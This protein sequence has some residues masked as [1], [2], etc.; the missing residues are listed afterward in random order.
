[1][2]QIYKIEK[3]NDIIEFLEKFDNAEIY[4]HPCFKKILEDIFDY[5]S[6]YLACE[7]TLLPFFYQN[8]T[9]FSNKKRAVSLPIFT[10]GGVIGSLEH[11][12]D[13]LSYL[14]KEGFKEAI[15]KE[16]GSTLFKESFQS[17]QAEYRKEL[18]SEEEIWRGLNKGKKSNVNSGKK[19]NLKIDITKGKE[20]DIDEFYRLYLP[21]MREFGTPPL[22]KEMFV[23]LKECFKERFNLYR[24]S[25]EDE[26]L[27]TTICI[28]FKDIY[29][30]IYAAYDTPL[31]RKYKHAQV[32]MI[33]NM[34]VDGLNQGYKQ[35]SFGRSTKDS[36]QARTKKHMGA[37]EI[38]LYHYDIDLTNMN[39]TQK[40][41]KQK[42]FELLVSIWRMLPLK[43]T[44][45]LG[46]PARKFLS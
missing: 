42:D 28:G 36:P 10:N 5:K 16:L 23:K 12:D 45:I 43:L 14:K 22:P 37:K 18:I 27:G 13:I 32:Y 2:K 4:H 40:E 46:K 24:I 9:L 33:Y 19:Q 31:S 29:Y 6:L 30:Y 11:I 44:E 20:C 26:L 7:D 21:K 38:D 35:F 39:I 15:I 3:D 8:P 41:H 34:M 25:K 17:S 1:M